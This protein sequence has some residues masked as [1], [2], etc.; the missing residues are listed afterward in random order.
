MNLPDL[1]EAKIRTKK[2]IRVILDDYKVPEDMKKIGV[3]Q[4]YYIKTYGCQMNVHDS[5]NLKA[6]LEDMSFKES[7]TMEEADFILLNTC[8]IREN[9]HNKMYGFLGRVKHLKESKPNI[10]CGICGCMAQEESVVEDIKTKYKWVDIVFGTH[11]IHKLPNIL[12]ES[13][14]KQKQEIE[15]YS[16]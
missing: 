7:D 4:K 14:N 9:A 11:N 1:K 16:I 13:L 3:G 10:I 12:E 6:I 8:A 2:E 15:V 5:E